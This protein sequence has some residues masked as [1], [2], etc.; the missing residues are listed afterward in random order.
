VISRRAIAGLVLAVVLVS[1]VGLTPVAIL[2]VTSPDRAIATC[3]VVRRGDTITLIFRNSMFG[4]DVRETFEVSGDQALMRTRVITEN[5]ASADY[6]AWD[7]RVLPVEGGFQVVV[8]PQPFADLT[9]R[10]DQ[11]GRHRLRIG[12]REIALFS[13]LQDSR[14]TA[15]RLD[16]VR[17]PL[18]SRIVS[19]FGPGGDC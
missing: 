17:E 18:V 15:V 3:S 9:I 1:G 14:S 12:D 4:G 8:P 16:V 2:R 6:Y 11:V 19:T 13:Q 10:V 7:G 5:A